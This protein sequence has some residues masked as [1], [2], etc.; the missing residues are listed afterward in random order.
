[1]QK[2]SASLSNLESR[3]RLE[4]NRKDWPRSPDRRKKPLSKNALE[5][6][7]KESLRKLELLSSCVLKRKPV[8]QKSYDYKKKL[9]FKRSRD[10]NKRD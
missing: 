6:K 7:R 9:V 3:K 10:S 4:L 5:L 2:E 1:M 8:K